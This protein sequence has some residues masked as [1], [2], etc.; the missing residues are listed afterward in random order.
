VFNKDE[1]IL[2]AGADVVPLMFDKYAR[3]LLAVPDELLVFF[4]PDTADEGLTTA[5]D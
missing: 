3:Y 5:P 1:R 2:L 4:P